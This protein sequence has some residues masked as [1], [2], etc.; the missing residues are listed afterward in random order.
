MLHK[1]RPLIHTEPFIIDDVIVCLLQQV[2]C[3][4]QDTHHIY[5]QSENAS[6][7]FQYS[8]LL[9]IL[10]LLTY[11]T[12]WRRKTISFWIVGL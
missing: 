8:T 11:T 7:F 2:S 10:L 9:I 3:I 1:Q 4:L 12:G 6:F 5:T